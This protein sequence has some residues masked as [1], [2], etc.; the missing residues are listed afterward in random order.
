M[1]K[2]TARRWMVISLLEIGRHPMTSV[3]DVL[4]NKKSNAM[5]VFILFSTEEN[6]VSFLSPYKG[7]EA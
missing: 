3:H 7:T 2:G 1:L 5:P 6:P 4:M